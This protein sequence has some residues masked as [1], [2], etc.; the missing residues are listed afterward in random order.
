MTH[1]VIGAT[2]VATGVRVKMRG[3]GDLIDLMAQAL[4]IERRG[5]RSTHAAGRSGPGD[6]PSERGAGR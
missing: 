2:V 5:W 1:S 6:G 3:E 4:A